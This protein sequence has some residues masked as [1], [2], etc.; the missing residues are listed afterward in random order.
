MPEIKELLQGVEPLWHKGQAVALTDG[1]MAT[2]L[3]QMGIP[4]GTPVEALNRTS[5]DLV[6]DVHRAYLGAGVQVLQ[7]NTFGAHAPGL[8]RYGLEDQVEEINRAGARLALEA[9]AGAAVVYGTMG[10]IFGG[11]RPPDLTDP[12]QRRWVRDAYKSQASS[13]LGERIHGLVLETFP[14]LEELVLALQVVR[15]LTDLPI[16]ATLSPE[17]AGVTRDGVR[18]D[19][20]FSRLQD[21]GAQVVGLNCRLGP[22]GILRSYEKAPPRTGGLYAAVPNAGLLHFSEGRLAYSGDAAYFAEILDHLVDLG[23]RWVG[24]CCGTTPHYLQTVAARLRD[25]EKPP[26]GIGLALTAGTERDSGRSSRTSTKRVELGQTARTLVDLVRERHAVIVELDPPKSLDCDRYLQGAQALQQ[27][28]ADL[29]TLADNSLGSVRMS[30]LALGVL[31]KRQG[32]EPLL[33]V[34]CRDRNLIGQQSHLM[35]LSLLDLHHILLVTGD[36]SRFGE[37]PG[38]TSVYD[39]ASIDLSRMVRRLNEGLGFTGQSLKRSSRFVIGTSFNPHARN[40]DKAIERLRRKIE[41]GAQFVMT[42]P[43][44]DEPLM[45]RMAEQTRSL[46]APLFVGIMP[47]I[48]ARHTLFMQHEVPGMSIPQTVSDLMLA[49]AADDR[50]A[51]AQGL[52][53]AQRLVTLAKSYFNGLYLITPFLRYPLTANLAKL[54]RS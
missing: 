1:A 51:E 46:G 31:L 14:D 18:L 45:E 30:N 3:Y 22:L 13:L 28:G 27:A 24:G 36:P 35:G 4:V 7:T 34:N 44:Y 15:A 8:A 23:V 32:I 54:A 48:N 53:I 37:L 19:Q 21:A 10:A 52:E 39:A 6:A 33:H 40:L 41:A 25:A 20:A 50:A 29:I 38:A 42:Q 5:P 9:A 47:L 12:Q 17:E 16:V 2:W 43:V 26:A 11:S 49:Y